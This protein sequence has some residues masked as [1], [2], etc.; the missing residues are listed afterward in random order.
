MPLAEKCSLLFSSHNLLFIEKTIVIA[1]MRPKTPCQA[2]LTTEP[3]LYVC[4][5]ATWSCRSSRC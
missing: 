5:A 4:R 2:L 3:A 1:L